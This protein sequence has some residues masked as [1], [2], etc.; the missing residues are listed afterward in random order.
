MGETI[1]DRIKYLRNKM[2][3]SM[4]QLSK[5]LN[6]STPQAIH[7][8]E[9]GAANPPYDKLITI[10]K[11]AN[12]SIDWIL[13]GKEFSPGD[14]TT[15]EYE[16]VKLFRDLPEYQDAILTMLRGLKDVSNVSQRLKEDMYKAAEEK[17]EY[18]ANHKDKNGGKK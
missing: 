11:L 14:L 6:L 1:A 2:N 16:V 10:A 7:K 5:E 9:S 12:V 15:V 4:R 13:T 3:M 18:L 8:Y 17:H